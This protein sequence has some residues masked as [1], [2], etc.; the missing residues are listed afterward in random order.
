MPKRLTAL[1]LA[2]VFAVTARAEGHSDGS[3]RNVAAEHALIYV[4]TRHSSR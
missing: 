1:L 3:A 4:A 2:A